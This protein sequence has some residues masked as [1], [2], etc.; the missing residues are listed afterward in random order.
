M[1]PYASLLFLLCLVCTSGLHAQSGIASAAAVPDSVWFGRVEAGAEVVDTVWI[2]AADGGPTPT[3]LSAHI[4]AQHDDFSVVELPSSSP[5]AD[6]AVVVRYRSRHNVRREAVLFIRVE[7][8]HAVYS[9]PVRLAGEA[10]YTDPVYEFTEGLR[11]RALVDALRGYVQGHTVLTY[12]QARD[13]MFEQIDKRQDDTLECPYSGRKI[14]VISRQHAQQNHS[15][16]T[17]HTWPQSLG[18]DSE[19]PKSDL[20]HLRATDLTIND[21]RANYPFGDVVGSVDYQQGGSKLGKNTSGATV[22]EVRDRY[23]GDIA[24]GMFYFA[25]RYNNPSSYLNQ[26]EQVLR[27]W[28]EFDT[29]DAGEAARNAAIAQHQKRRNPFIDHP[30]F[31]ERIYSLAG[32]G[33][34]PAIADPVF[35]DSVYILAVD[36]P[37]EFPL[38]LG[39]RGTDTAFVR[40]VEV[41]SGGELRN[42]LL[43]AV[44]SVLAPDGVLLIALRRPKPFP[45]VDSVTVTVRF[46]M[47][48]PQQKAVVRLSALTGVREQSGD[49]P[50]LQAVPTPF[51][52]RTTVAFSTPAACAEPGVRIVTMSGREVRG[53]AAHVDYRNGTT[54]VSLDASPVVAPGLLFCRITCGSQV[55]MCPLLLV[56]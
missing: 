48:I 39:N 30:E 44:D 36:G 26:Q 51:T 29:V 43:V 55:Y 46:R 15:F 12:N 6:T 19:P 35:S 22:F 40:S 8:R 49:V 2:R 41:E 28:S 24:R 27:R 42:D 33:D 3:I 23:K 50:V 16:N 1:N 4:V 52:G 20:Y 37:V 32:G 7:D 53:I 38:L 47:G 11:G 54:T 9:V 5:V 34:A 10:Y 18:A 56:R 17:E 25:L 45:G 14:R 21:K 31:M 13:L